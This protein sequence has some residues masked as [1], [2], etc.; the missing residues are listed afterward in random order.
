MRFSH[1]LSILSRNALMR[2]ALCCALA[3]GLLPADVYA[4]TAPPVVHAEAMPREVWTAIPGFESDAQWSEDYYA[5]LKGAVR[6]RMRLWQE[7]TEETAALDKAWEIGIRTYL[8]RV[9]AT[10][11][12]MNHPDTAQRAAYCKQ[13]STLVHKHFVHTEGRRELGE[14]RTGGFVFRTKPQLEAACQNRAFRLTGFALYAVSAWVMEDRSTVV[15]EACY[16]HNQFN[17]PKVRG[18]EQVKM[19]GRPVVPRIANETIKVAANGTGVIEKHWAVDS[20]LALVT[21]GC[22]AGLPQATR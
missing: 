7:S 15:V 20:D 10:M 4:Q 13:M 2:A 9:S 8:R 16:V 18:V 12:G 21:G 19:N 6:P 11:G 14:D 5:V 1:L 22:R 17:D 3:T